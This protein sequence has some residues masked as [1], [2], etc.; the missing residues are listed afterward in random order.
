MSAIELVGAPAAV[1]LG[2]CQSGVERRVIAA[3]GSDVSF[4]AY[5]P[6]R[7]GR[8]GLVGERE[9]RMWRRQLVNP[10]AILFVVAKQ[11]GGKRLGRDF[12]ALQCGRDRVTGRL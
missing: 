9:N 5:L 4:L 7:S 12:A 10:W 11:R 6:A 3:R 2:L 1:G 8:R